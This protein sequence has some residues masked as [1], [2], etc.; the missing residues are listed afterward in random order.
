MIHYRKPQPDEAEAFAA[1]HVQCWREAY[2]DILPRELLASFSTQSRLPMWQAAL[3]NPERFILGAYADGTPVGFVM[4]G[5]SVE[6]H[7]PE[8]DGHLW[9]LYI[10]AAQHRQGIGRVLVF[11]AAQHWLDQGG[12]T[13]TIGVLTENK[14]ARAF[15]ESLGAK[16]LKHNTYNWSGFELPDCL[17]IWDDLAKIAKV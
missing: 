13:M 11:A 17:Y 8:Q 4:S 12:S 5:P 15:Y 6:K 3:V 16:L 1:L 14:P 2:A 9:A 10:A 7:I